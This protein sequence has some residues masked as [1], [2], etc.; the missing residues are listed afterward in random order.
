LRRISTKGGAPEDQ[1][2][3]SKNRRP[4]FTLDIRFEAGSIS[5]SRPGG[6]MSI[7][8]KSDSVGTAGPHVGP[9]RSSGLVVLAI[10]RWTVLAAA[11]LLA[12]LASAEAQDEK[13][14]RIYIANDDHTD[15]MWMADESGYQGAFLEMLDYYLALAE[16]TVGEPKDWQSRWNCDGSFWLWTFE[17][18][19]SPE[20]FE[21]AI[22]QLRSGHLSA[23]LNAL[24][25]CYGAQ[26]AEA[27]L[28]G[29]YYSGRLER[30]TGLRFPLVVAMEN[31]TL[32]LG[33][34][35]LWQGAGARWT[36]R[37]V[38]ACSSKMPRATEPRDH[39]I[40]WMTGLDGSRL[41]MKWYSL[42][43]HTP[44]DRPSNASLGG[45]A[46][47]RFPADAIEYLDHDEGFR[48]RYRDPKSSEPYRVSA[49]FGKGW[50][51][52]KTLT[53]EFPR[54]ARAQS[55]ERRQ[56]IVSNEEDFFADF[57]REY[58]ASLPAETVA[59]GNE[60][61]LYSASLAEVSS[62]VKRSVEKLR[63]AEALAT[64]VSILRPAFLDGRSAARDLAFM[65]LGLYWEHDWTADGP[66]PRDG[67]AAWQRRLAGELASYVDALHRDA[68]SALGGLIAGSGEHPRF[69]VFNPLGW[70]RTEAA[71]LPWEG[72][73]PCHVVDIAT[74]AEVPSERSAQGGLGHLRILAQE[75]PSVGYRVYEVRPGPGKEFGPAG[76]SSGLTIENDEVRVTLSGRGALTSVVAKKLGNRELVGGVANDLGGTGGEV[77]Q[78][79]SGPVSITLLARGGGPPRRDVRVTLTRGSPRID[80]D[81]EI[82]ENFSDVLAWTFQFDLKSPDVHH[83]EVGAVLRA[84]LTT[85]G[86]HY[87][88]RQAR[89]DWLTLN[90]FAD[91]T[92]AG[93]I[94][95]TLANRDCSFFRLGRSS[96]ERLDSASA[97]AAVLA[98]G[99]VDGVKLGIVSQGG[100]ARFLQRFALIPHGAYDQTAA[101]KGALEHQNPL[102]AARVRGD[103]KSPYPA[104]SYSLLDLSSADVLLWALKPAEE[105]IAGGVIARMWNQSEKPADLKL[106]VHAPGWKASVA[107]RC[108]HLETDL[109]PAK[110]EDGK[111]SVQL[112]PQ[113]LATFR[114]LPEARASSSGKPG[115]RR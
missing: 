12:A 1:I 23:P 86:G 75:V 29:M 94:G 27:V 65:N 81:N 104:D 62:G 20:Q 28:R 109:E 26:P 107:R 59:R 37:G 48:R 60:W 87:A 45:Y 63:S 19:R 72:T 73:G 43:L 102:V 9:S 5:S 7:R 24:A 17:R 34:A 67:R 85:E 82:T 61:D 30:R 66:V 38:C 44:K 83:E 80:L 57:E 111:V 2:H 76:K 99:Q 74:E 51:D 105:G 54:I 31:Q 78:E 41:L 8:L 110:V 42:N 103:A 4:S 21:R 108:T 100:D 10:L 96:P 115:D 97:G 88:P 84:K 69:Y 58:G 32:P 89:T 79:S 112:K 33:V 92:G 64:L 14:K 90:H 16:K 93:E 95:I 114:L 101:M 71:D 77:V 98:G 52:L 3:G 22:A 39:E 36:W 11:W 6:E 56:V 40:Y 18:H 55:N 70:R 68:A 50:D 106:A 49:A 46:E 15:Y 25:S 91:F 53:D 47:A 13:P 113:G 35:S